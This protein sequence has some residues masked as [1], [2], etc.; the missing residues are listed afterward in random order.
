LSPATTI[1]QTEEINTD[2][3][4]CA[5]ASTIVAPL[6]IIV[7]EHSNPVTKSK[8]VAFTDEGLRKA[9]VAFAKLFED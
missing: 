4:L 3:H 7:V 5:G 6:T 2:N 9:K 1:P 8:V